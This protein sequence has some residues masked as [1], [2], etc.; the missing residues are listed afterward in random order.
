[1][2]LRARL[3]ASSTLT[4][5]SRLCRKTTG[6]TAGSYR[7]LTRQCRDAVAAVRDSAPAATVRPFYFFIFFRFF[8]ALAQNLTF[9]FFFFFFFLT[10][11]RPP[12]PLSL[13][14][15]SAELSD[16]SDIDG[17]GV[18]GDGDLPAGARPFVF[19][20]DDP[21][22]KFGQLTIKTKG[23]DIDAGTAAYLA[24]TAGSR[25]K[26]RKQQSPGECVMLMLC[27][28]MRVLCWCH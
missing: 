23:A 13:F 3:M 14:P 28:C 24:K 7:T 11:Q 5:G 25:K 21:A 17:G 4:L 9:F 15:P 19:A 10:K 22:V 12:S 26:G 18:G 1:M 8:R 16:G 2:L 6:A 20:E 27:V